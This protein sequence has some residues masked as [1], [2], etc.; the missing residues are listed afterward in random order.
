MKLLVFGATGQTGRLVVERALVENHSVT[1]LVRD[2]AKAAFG[3]VR[4]VTGDARK[5]DDVAQ[6]MQGQDAVISAIGG[7]TPW[8]VTQLESA[9][10]RAI[11]AA[12]QA[13]GGARR[14]AVV[15]MMGIGTSLA[16]TPALYR[17]LLMPTF[18]R[19]TTIDKTAMEAAIMASGLDYVIA[20]PPMLT[21]APATGQSRVLKDG[22]TGHKITRADLAAFL[23]EQLQS[24]A[25]LRRAVTVVN[26]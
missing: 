4:V 5:A 16:Q 24:D 14:L 26:S 13:A 19:G 23:V 2:P 3:N 20:R 15:S 7:T 8:K 11:V 25:Y 9:T 22:E 18:L 21:N 1:I 10:M 17:Y 12:M 6:A